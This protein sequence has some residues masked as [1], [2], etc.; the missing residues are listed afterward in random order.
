MDKVD[1]LV[2]IRTCRMYVMNALLLVASLALSGPTVV[3]AIDL[4]ASVQEGTRW[5]KGV[6]QKLHQY[7]ELGFKEIDTSTTLRLHMDQL[8]IPYTY[9]PLS[10]HRQT[11]AAIIATP[12]ASCVII[13]LQARHGG[14]Y[15]YPIAKTGFSATIGQGKPV[16]ALRSDIDALPIEEPRG[17]VWFTS[18]V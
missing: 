16:V 9:A 10:M 11:L 6:R 15:R 4:A 12:V 7:P 18:R 1:R 8:D 5:I 13:E 17:R 3:G 14:L 2:A